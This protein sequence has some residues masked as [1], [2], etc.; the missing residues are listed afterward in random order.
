DL[1]GVDFSILNMTERLTLETSSLSA[2]LVCA[3]ADSQWSYG[4]VDDLSAGDLVL[5]CYGEDAQPSQDAP[6]WIVCQS[7]TIQDSTGT[8]DSTQE[9]AS[10]TADSAQESQAD[11]VDSQTG[12]QTQTQSD[13][14]GTDSAAEEQAASDTQSEA[15]ASDTVGDT[16]DSAAQVSGSDTGS[17]DASAQTTQ[18]SSYTVSEQTLLSITPQDTMDITITV[19]ELDILL[20]EVGQSAQVTLDAI[21]GQSFEGTVTSIDLTGTSSEGNTKYTAV[22]TIDRG[23]DMLSGMNA[24]VLITLETQENVLTV[25]AEAL[26]E[27]GSAT[28]VYTTYNEQTDTL[29]GLVEVTTGLSDGLMVEVTSG[30]S[31]GDTYYYSYLDTVNYSVQSVLSS[32]SFSFSSMLGGS[33]R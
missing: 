23:E 26:Y 15:T 8:A 5:V 11:S 10:Q 4:T 22:V 14:S 19:D 32:G 9:D 33:T 16:S 18:S 24:S 3:Y 27:D 31:E 7:L 25:P 6:V 13:L 29:G 20:L 2:T 30:L 1:S 17:E 21:A 12:L 28:Y